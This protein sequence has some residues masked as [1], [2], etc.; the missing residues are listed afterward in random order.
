ME[1]KITME[2]SRKSSPTLQYDSRSNFIRTLGLIQ[3]SYR[4][5]LFFF[6]GKC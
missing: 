2:E 1:F 4:E 6:L 5:N 3:D